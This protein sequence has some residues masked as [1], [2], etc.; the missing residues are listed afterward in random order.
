MNERLLIGGD[1]KVLRE[2]AICR[3]FL[4]FHRSLFH[5]FRAMLPQAANNSVH[6][7]RRRPEDI[8]AGVAGIVALLADLDLADRKGSAIG[9]DFIQH[10]G[11]DQRI[12]DM[13]AQFDLFGKHGPKELNKVKSVSQLIE[14]QSC[15]V[16][17]ATTR[18]VSRPA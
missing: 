6:N 5:Y 1:I 15:M 7:L 14:L 11:Q 12:N 17:M 2:H 18:T 13:P 9:Q 4:K 10:F 3:R 8:D 16:W